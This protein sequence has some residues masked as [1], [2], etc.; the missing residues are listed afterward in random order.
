MRRSRAVAAVL[1]ASA[2]AYAAFAC[3]PTLQAPRESVRISGTVQD[4]VEK[5][6]PA[7]SPSPTPPAD[8]ATPVA[9]GTP[10][11][12][13]GKLTKSKPLQT[14]PTLTHMPLGVAI[15]EACSPQ[16]YF[17]KRCP[18]RFLGEAKLAHP[19]PFVV[20]I[21][22]QA[23]EVVVFAYRG[24]LGP[25]QQ[26]EACAEMKV[27]IADAAKPIALQLVPGTCSIKLEKRYG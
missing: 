21:D 22:T 20:E 19:G 26:Q 12:A 15:Y 14:F 2:L 25:E 3:T 9:L 17:F 10:T 6:T 11:P 24:F 18:G 23:S 1:L 8:A 13:A 5:P 4:V 7:P 16:L 27:A